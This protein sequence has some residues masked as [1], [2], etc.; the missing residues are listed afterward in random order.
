MTSNLVITIIMA[1]VALYGAALSTYNAIQQRKEKKPSIKVS[2]GIGMITDAM[3]G[4][5]DAMIVLTAANTG[6]IPVTLASAG[7]FLPNSQQ[8]IFPP[9]ALNV[10][11]PYE[12]VPGKSC[13]IYREA[14]S[15][16]KSIKE[17]Q[18]N[19][20]IDVVVFFQDEVGNTYKSKKTKLDLDGWKA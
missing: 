9:L 1:I 12:L 5:S 19:G 20:K 11:F 3:G 18:Y 13:R 7:L 10:R 17:Q 14:T 2:Q 6:H 15:I 16:V 8:M 4:L